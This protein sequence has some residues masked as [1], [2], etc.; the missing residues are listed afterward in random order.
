MKADTTLLPTVQ[1]EV[2][3]KLGRCLLRLQQYERLLKTMLASMKL[4]GAPDELLAARDG[5][6]AAM[7]K[8]SL[9]TLVKQLI[10][11]HITAGPVSEEGQ[12]DGGDHPG[13]ASVPWIDIHYS[14]S[15]KPE[16]YEE[17][18]SDLAEF[19]GLRNDLVHHLIERFDIS[20]VD[21]CHAASLHLDTCYER[22]ERGCLGLKGWVDAFEELR[23][24]MALFIQSEE[25]ENAV[26]HGITP[27][28]TVSW[29]SS[30]VVEDLRSA[31][32]CCQI[33][34][35]TP[36][37]TAII[38]IAKKDR[39]QVPSRYG[40]KT[41]RQLLQRSGQF[42][43]RRTGTANGAGRTWYRSRTSG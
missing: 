15:I 23:T 40:C 17:T 9:G 32:S 30:S 24:K 36:L 18:I 11:E 29:E 6:S 2:Q 7:H 21:G 4:M 42:E 1:Q 3:R 22:I 27:D 19:V 10:G 41:W 34:G 8:K 5:Q 43:S 12:N 20:S 28:G 39:A 37:D 16:L 14:I 31:E 35:W 25:F 33:E 38:F 26:I 13:F